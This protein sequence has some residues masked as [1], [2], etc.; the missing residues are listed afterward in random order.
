[1]SDDQWLQCIVYFN[2]ACAYCGCTREQLTADHLDPK[3]KGGRNAP[4]NIVPACNACNE[5]KADKDWRE[6]M[7]SRDDFS[8]ERMNR[9]FDWRRICRLAKVGPKDG[10]GKYASCCN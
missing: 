8:Q 5:E 7:M 2:G 9:I 4:E 6:Y 1:M 10:G 3:S